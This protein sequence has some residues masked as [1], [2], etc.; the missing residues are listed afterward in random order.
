MNNKIEV[1]KEAIENWSQKI[2]EDVLKTF[3]LSKNDQTT[4]KNQITERLYKEIDNGKK[5]FV[6]EKENG[7][8]EFVIE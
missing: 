6:V 8:N 7:K 3:S 1:N 4:F 5:V 2:M